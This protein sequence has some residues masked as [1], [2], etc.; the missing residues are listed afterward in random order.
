[1]QEGFGRIYSLQQKVDLMLTVLNHIKDI[2][3]QITILA[4]NS[5][6]EAARAGKAGAGF[7]V[8]ADEIRKLAIKIESIVK[9]ILFKMK[10]LQEEMD[11]SYEFF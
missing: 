4:I 1:M 3:E 9:D 2:S 10:T 11:K 5:S 8:I 6:I 7:S